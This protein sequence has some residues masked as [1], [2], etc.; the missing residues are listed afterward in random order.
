MNPRSK[1]LRV[2]PSA[3]DINRFIL[4]RNKTGETV[5]PVGIPFWRFSQLVVKR[6]DVNQ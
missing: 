3:E 1:G 2:T 4:I 5:H 6:T